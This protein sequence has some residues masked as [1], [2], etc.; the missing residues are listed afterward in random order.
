M[1]S[2]RQRLAGTVFVLFFFVLAGLTL[3]SNTLQTALLP[4]A[5]TEKPLKKTLE[6][7][8]KGSG[9]LVPRLKK[10][11]AGENGWPIAQVHVTAGDQVTKGQTLVTFDDTEALQLLLDEEARMKKQSINRELLQEQ[12]IAAQQSGNGE[13]VRKAE[14]DLELEKIDSEIAK[15][16]LDGMRKD[17]ARKRVLTAPFDGKVAALKAEKGAIAAQGQ[18]LVTLIKSDEGFELSFQTTADSAA[19]LQSGEKVAVNVKS[20]TPVRLEGA[21]TDIKDSFAEGTGGAMGKPDQSDKN[22]S[23][24]DGVKQKK[25]V[26]VTVSGE[27]LQ[28]GEQAS[29]Q[30]DKKSSQQGLVIRK[31]W[32]KKDGNGSYVFVIREKKSALGNAYYAQKAYLVT[33][34]SAED[35][36]VVLS[37]L[38]SEDD[39]ITESSEPLQ[40]GSQVRLQG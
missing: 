30:V 26:V 39:L 24:D 29:L 8:I 7:H 36:I 17:I 19:L 1:T 25:T 4:K 37:G 20:P 38:S 22:G 3:F 10:E 40:D 16:K 21:I 15:R 35:G 18:M 34:E 33:G 13:A 9:T 23:A 2:R 14:R 32:L 27:G 28:G 6:H 12:F 5:V 11:L 31:E